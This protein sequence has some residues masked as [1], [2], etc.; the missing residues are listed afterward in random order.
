MELEF[1]E[2]K[3][4]ID[5]RV[6]DFVL[7]VIKLVRSL[8]KEAV[9]REMRRQ[10]LRAATSIAANIEEARGGFSKGDFTFKM[11]TAFKEARETNLW[12]RL[13]RDSELMSS[14]RIAALIR[15]SEEIRNILGASVKTAKKRSEKLEIRSQK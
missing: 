8:P 3:I 13:I 15:E 5:E 9:E 14:T 12:L 7:R 2:Q 6:Y 4:D 11:N 1:K 10:L